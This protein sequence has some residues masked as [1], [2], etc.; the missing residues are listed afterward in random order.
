MII[1]LGFLFSGSLFAQAA[2]EKGMVI[3]GITWATRNVDTSGTFAAKPESAGKFYQWNRNKAWDA[4]E[5]TVSGWDGSEVLGDIWER[6]N[7]P[8]PVGWHIP[9]LNEIGKLLDTEKVSNEWTSINGINGRKFTDKATGNSI[10]LPAAGYRDFMDGTLAGTG[11][12]GGYWNSTPVGNYAFSLGFHGG[13]S[14]WRKY[15]NYHRT[16]GF[17]VRPAAD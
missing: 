5:E 8:S 3:N 9:T 1:A 10:F 17:S 7:D 14:N 15:Y 2:S 4:T 12:Y 11:Y 6:S 13:N 16:F